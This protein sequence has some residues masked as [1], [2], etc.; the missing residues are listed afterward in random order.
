VRP[1]AA[2]ALLL[3][4]LSTAAAPAASPES[5]VARS[6][7][8]FEAIRARS[9]EA[10]R[11]A[12]C[13]AFVVTA[14]DLSHLTR[15]AAGRRWDELG[16]ALHSA[17]AAAISRRMVN[18]CTNI[19]DRPEQGPAVVRRVRQ[20]SGAVRVTAQLQD[21]GRVFVWTLR[22]GGAWGFKAL[23]LIV[24][25]RSVAVT[26]RDEFEAQLSIRGGDARMAINDLAR[27]GRN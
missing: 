21:T 10:S 27:I 8:R 22:H 17:L 13:S 3:L 4:S 9:G 5:F 26:L 23:D 1:V 15:A 24:D 6:Q 25:G 11:R 12:D 2:L 19:L 18:E 14:F 7:E 20:I 16:P